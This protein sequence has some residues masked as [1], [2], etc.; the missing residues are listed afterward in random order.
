MQSLKALLNDNLVRQARLFE[1]MT[2]S[3]RRHLP[4]E[5]A[6]HCWVGGVR[7]RIL[8]VVTDSASFGVVAYYQQHEILKG[9]NSEFRAELPA[10]LIKLRTK[11]ARAPAMVES[12]RQQPTTFPEGTRGPA[13]A[14]SHSAAPELKSAYARLARRSDKQ[15]RR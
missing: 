12:P 5:A 1:T 13:S 7:D 14:A 9:M 11:V 4:A 3:L 15:S 8:V 2:Q 6:A 10:P